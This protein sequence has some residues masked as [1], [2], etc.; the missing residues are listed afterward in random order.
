M[1]ACVFSCGDVVACRD[2]FVRRYD[3]VARLCID[4][5]LQRRGCTNAFYLLTGACRARPLTGPPQVSTGLP[6]D[7]CDRVD[8][9]Y[10]YVDSL[11]AKDA[12]SDNFA[13]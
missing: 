2:Q 1:C 6:S 4:V 13:A 12:L 7:S 5:E 11:L 10:E 9:R 3:T 8:L